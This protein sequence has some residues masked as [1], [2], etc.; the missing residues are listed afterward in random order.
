MVYPSIFF[1]YTN[2]NVEN[3]VKDLCDAFLT[4]NYNGK[5]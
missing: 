1:V 5:W 2:I 3:A 4:N